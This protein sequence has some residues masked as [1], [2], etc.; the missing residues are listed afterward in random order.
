M[1]SAER[2]LTEASTRWRGAIS[3]TIFQRLGSEA[4]QDRGVLQ[5]ALGDDVDQPLLQ[6]AIELAVGVGLDLDMQL[7]SAAREDV[8]HLIEGRHARA[9]TIAQLRRGKL[10]RGLFRHEPCPSVVR[11][12]VGSWI[13]TSTP[14]REGWTSNSTPSMPSARVRRKPSRLFS[15]QRLRAPR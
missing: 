6:P 3:R 10:G 9:A 2:W 5:L 14:S 12:S 11:S 1:P 4:G 8:E 7:D 15:G 13:T